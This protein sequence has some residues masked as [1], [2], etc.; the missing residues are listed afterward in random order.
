[1]LCIRDSDDKEFSL[2]LSDEG[3]IFLSGVEALPA[4][5]AYEGWLVADSGPVSTGILNVTE[6]IIH[7]NFTLSGANLFANFHTFVVSVEPVPDPDPAPSAEKPYVKT[8]DPDVL[9]H[10]RHLTYS[11]QGNPVYAAGPHAGT[12][13]GIAVGL[14]EQAALAL[15]HANLAGD[16]GTLAGIKQHAEHVVNIIDGGAG[17]DLD[18]VGGAQNPG[19][20]G[21]GVL[22]YADDTIKHAEFI[23]AIRPQEYPRNAILSARQAKV[24]AESARERVM[25]ALGATERIVARAAVANASILLDKTL[26]GF[27]ASG[28]GSIEPKKGEAGAV[29]AYLFSQQTGVYILPSAPDTTVTQPPATPK[30]PGGGD[31][32]V[33]SLAFSGLILGIV[34][35]AVGGTVL[36]G[37]SRRRGSAV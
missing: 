30:P 25:A 19:D 15:F 10:V 3:I 26:N 6:G 11:W 35:L 34:L 7:Q 4:D 32:S 9:A 31:A 33:P 24:W 20:K 21:P 22:G 37:F 5:K 8:L 1:M 28:S 27:D 23:L 18:G 12:P 14:R 2:T 17:E 16:Q 36:Y 13:K 29:H